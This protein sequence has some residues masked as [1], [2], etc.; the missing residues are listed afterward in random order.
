MEQVVYVY[1]SSPLPGR[2]CWRSDEL[3]K[4]AATLCSE[5]LLKKVIISPIKLCYLLNESIVLHPVFGRT[6]RKGWTLMKKGKEI[7]F[8]IK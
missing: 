6:P 3:T 8:K 5:E 4:V 7:Y 2:T 1:D